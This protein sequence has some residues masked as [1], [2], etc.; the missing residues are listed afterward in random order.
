MLSSSQGTRKTND[1]LIDGH[2]P[3]NWVEG[4]VAKK[5]VQRETFSVMHKG[6]GANLGYLEGVLGGEIPSVDS[7]VSEL[8]LAELKKVS[9]GPR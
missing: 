7:F 2:I 1:I 8:T 6:P 5:K 9:L 4:K 3:S